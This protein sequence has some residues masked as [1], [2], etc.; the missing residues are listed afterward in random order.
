MVERIVDTDPMIVKVD[1][2]EF[3]RIE[4]AYAHIGGTVDDVG[5]DI[6]LILVEGCAVARFRVGV[7]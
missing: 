4:A 6:K 3:A 5:Q 2:E 7:Q 1:P